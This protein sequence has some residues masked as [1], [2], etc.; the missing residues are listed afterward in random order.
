[1]TPQRAVAWT[2]AAGL[3]KAPAHI[4]PA[5]TAEIKRID[6]VFHQRLDADFGTDEHAWPWSARYAYRSTVAAIH[7]Q[8]Q[9]ETA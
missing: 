4:S 9:K 6:G 8:H 1:M 7:Q 2:A 5:E 3:I